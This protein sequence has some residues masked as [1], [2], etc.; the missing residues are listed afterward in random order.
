MRTKLSPVDMVSKPNVQL[1]S[2]PVYIVV[3][4]YATLNKQVV[5]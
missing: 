5:V 3:L 1:V 4:I 2:Y